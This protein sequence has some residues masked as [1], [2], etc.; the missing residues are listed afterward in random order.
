VFARVATWLEPAAVRD[1]TEQMLA[2]QAADTGDVRPTPGAHAALAAL[3]D[4][5]WAIV[6]SGDRRL[7]KARIA[8]AGLP[9]P[10]VLVTSDDVR[11]GKPDP[12]CYLLAAADLGAEPGRCLVVEDAPAGVAAGR[13]AGMAVLGLLTTY[14]DLAA[15]YVVADLSGVRVSTTGS[16]VTLALGG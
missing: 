9:V 7:A 4:D 8:A 2:Q 6:T 1:L 3:P 14:E 5:R 11:A 16:G 13:A 12:E 15:T 10:R